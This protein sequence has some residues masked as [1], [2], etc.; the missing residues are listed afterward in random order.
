MK[1]LTNKQQRFVKEY[2]VDFNATQAYMRVFKRKDGRAYKKTSA[3]VEGHKL[4][5][6]PNIAEAIE[7]EK[8]RL[9]KATEVDAEFVINGIKDTITRAKAE[10]NNFNAELNGYKLLGQTLAMF[11]QKQETSVEAKLSLVDLLESIE[12]D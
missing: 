12:E 3:A 2:V 9:N 6:N 11:T 4:L 1:E 7:Y 5:K 8:L 10:G